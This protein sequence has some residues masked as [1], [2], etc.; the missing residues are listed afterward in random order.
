MY[1]FSR[2]IYRELSPQISMPAPGHPA[3]SNHAAVLSACEAVVTRM[4]IDRHYFA[5]VILNFGDTK[6][7]DLQVTADMRKAG[8]YYVLAHAG[9]FTVWAS[10]GDH[11]SH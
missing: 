6:S 10:G 5:L 8:G 11:G 4:A 7:T 3:A 1:Q 2:A 9:Q